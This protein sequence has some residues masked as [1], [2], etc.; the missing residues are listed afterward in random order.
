M[1][2]NKYIWIAFALSLTFMLSMCNRPA[3]ESENAAPSPF[4]F[5]A[6]D[7]YGNTVTEASLGDKEL[8]F[9]HYWATWCGPCVSEMPD[10]AEVAKKYADKVG[11]IALLD[12]YG[13]A[14]STAVEIAENSGISFIMVDAN[15]GDFTALLSLVQSGYVPTTV[16]LDKDGNM[17]GEQIIGAY[18]AEY[19][20]YIEEALQRDQNGDDN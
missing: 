4:K 11:F 16:L 18:G 12:D 8:F 10:L 7:L 9:V 20:R 5:S 13:S 6:E 14:K 2:I 19:G 1:K 3:E 15:H 17:V